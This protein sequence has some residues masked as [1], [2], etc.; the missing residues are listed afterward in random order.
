MDENKALGELPIPKLLFKFS[1]PCVTGLLI[2]ALYNIV[3]QI[4]IGNSSLGYLGNAATG[5]SFPII[6]IANAFA[7][8]V[9]DGAASYLSICSGRQDSES[10]H[11]CVGTG[12]AATMIISIAL[13]AICLAFCKPLMVLFGASDATLAL[14]CDYFRIIALFFPAYLMFNVMNS[15]IRADGSP[16][17]AM[18]AMLSGAVLNIILDP[19]CIFVL[20]WGIQGAAIATVVGQVVS[21][22]ICLIY[23]F[24]PKSF[25]LTKSSFR[26][27][28]SMLRNLVVL[29]GSTFIIQISLVAMTLLSNIMLFKYGSL[30]VYGSDIPISVFSIQTKVY[31]I[32]SNIAVGIALGG[33]PILGYNYGAQKMDRVRQAYRLILLYSLSVGLIATLAFV[34]CPQIIIGI[35]GKQNAIYMDFAV[36]SFRISLGFSFVTCFIKISS[37]FF[38]SIGKAGHAMIASVIRDMLC[39]IGFTVILSNVMETRQSGTGI[40][41]IL[42]ASPL[43]DLVAGTVI[44]IITIRFFKKLDT[45]SDLKDAPI[46]ISATR[47]G[48]VVT[49]ARQHGTC[50][51]QIGELV[52]KKLG[53]PFYYKELTALVAKESG[54]AEEF[55]LND[56]D[57]PSEALNQLYL[58]TQVAQQ[59]IIAQEKVLRKIADAGA[60]V[61]VGRAANHVLRDYPNVVRVF[62]YAPDKF[63]IHNIQKMYG[64]SHAEARQHMLRSDESRANYYRNTSGNE[65]QSMENYDLCLNADIGKEAA[66]GIIEAYIRRC[67]LTADA[68]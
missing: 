68:T 58:S 34:F 39:F 60:C 10:A 14:S 33:Q 5:I 65:W 16:T 9:G 6:C 15:M 37:I 11:K 45:L 1:I 44:T 48:I 35:F 41:G 66:A 18:I 40:Y 38:Q 29:G 56:Y 24:K 17:Y 67:D 64:D 22:L 26:I 36:K 47:P 59:G 46:S 31:T 50:G 28:P 42:W 32:V 3:D 23:F 19:I 4:F 21:F 49:I 61:I 51:K 52:A 25:R 62:L 7:W 43:S 27:N 13:C 54:L 8:C 12:L 55:L 20:N 57:D 30:S 53:V 63:R 2:G